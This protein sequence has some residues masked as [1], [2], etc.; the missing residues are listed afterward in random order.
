[1][2]PPTHKYNSTLIQSD[3]TKFNI[4]KC[5]DILNN[6]EGGGGGRGRTSKLFIY[7]ILIIK[8]NITNIITSNI[9]MKKKWNK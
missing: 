7:N 3:K 6:H 9:A 2:T 4:P 1:M 5:L 8:A